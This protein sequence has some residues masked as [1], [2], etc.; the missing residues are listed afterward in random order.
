MREVFGEHGFHFNNRRASHKTDRSR[1]CCKAAKSRQ[2]HCEQR[3]ILNQRVSPPWGQGWGYLK[4]W[5]FIE[6]S[7]NF[8][9]KTPGTLRRSLSL[10]KGSSR[11]IQAHHF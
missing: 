2:N 7:P 8:L 3:T 5:I 10:K 11:T 6:Q 1:G 9:Q 4:D